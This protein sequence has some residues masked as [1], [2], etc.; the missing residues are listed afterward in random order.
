V[1]TAPSRKEHTRRSSR[2]THR[3]PGGRDALKSNCTNLHRE[4]RIK[5][6][7]HPLVA[8][9]GRRGSRRSHLRRQR[10][11]G[12]SRWIHQ[13]EIWQKPSLE[14]IQRQWQLADL[15]E[16]PAAPCPNRRLD[17]NR[18]SSA[19][20]RS[21]RRRT[22]RRYRAETKDKKKTYTKG[23][24]GGPASPLPVTPAGK[25]ARGGG[26]RSRRNSGDSQGKS[27][28]RGG[29]R[30]V[31]HCSYRGH[32]FLVATRLDVSVDAVVTV[33]TDQSAARHARSGL[34]P[35]ADPITLQRANASRSAC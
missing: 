29:K 23:C 28:R 24:T 1:K 25:A 35:G 3:P 9:A 12:R 34:T 32:C 8:T 19:E 6:A 30:V 10:R 33:C 16:R 27:G 2:G 7:P 4:S 18:R 21:Q 5:P 15:S 20:A 11:D 31:F 22:A 13:I 14:L 17:R 26:E